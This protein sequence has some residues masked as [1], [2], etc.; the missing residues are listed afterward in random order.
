MPE[1]IFALRPLRLGY[2]KDDEKKIK[3]WCAD[4]Q[5]YQPH[6]PSWHRLRLSGGY[7]FN[8]D[9]TSWYLGFT[10][11]CVLFPCSCIGTFLSFRHA[12]RRSDTPF[13]H[14][15]EDRLREL[16]PSYQLHFSSLHPEPYGDLFWLAMLPLSI[17]FGILWYWESVLRLL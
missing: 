4:T 1:S 11:F 2:W 6:I 9:S 8:S 13:S 17:G 3:H 5:L 14:S 12:L 16:V 10:V 15:E 7:R